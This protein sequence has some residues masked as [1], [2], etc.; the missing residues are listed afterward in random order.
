MYVYIYIYIYIHTHMYIYKYMCYTYV[1]MYCIYTLYIYP[2]EVHDSR[3]A[4]TPGWPLKGGGRRPRL[5][6]SASASRLPSSGRPAVGPDEMRRAAA[7]RRGSRPR[8]DPRA[9]SLSRGPGLGR[10]EFVSASI[11]TSASA[12]RSAGDASHL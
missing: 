10:G 8:D 6:S 1:C 7:R 2:A 9:E 11:R 4:P 5:A 3:V 12:V